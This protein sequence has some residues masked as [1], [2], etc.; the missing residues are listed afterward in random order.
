MLTPLTTAIDEAVEK[1]W[2]RTCQAGP[3][4]AIY[5]WFSQTAYEELK[6]NLAACWPPVPTREQ[7]Q[8]KF[9]QLGF[10]IDRGRLRFPNQ[11]STDGC[12]VL[13]DR[14][15]ALYAPVLNWCN[16]DCKNPWRWDTTKHMQWVRDASDNPGRWVPNPFTQF[17]DACGAPRPGR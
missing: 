16:P 9:L 7:I 15:A 11:V 3:G 17:C 4:A 5:R 6:R 1:A 10:F 14:I 13:V 12:D 2:K 8:E